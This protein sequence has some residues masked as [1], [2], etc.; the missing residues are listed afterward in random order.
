MVVL[1]P[2]EPRE[3]GHDDEVGF[4]LVGAAVVQQLLQFGAVCGVRALAFLPEPLDDFVSLTPA[5]LLA[6][7]ELRPQA[8]ILGLLLRAHANVDDGADH[9]SQLSAVLRVRQGDRYSAHGSYSCG[10]R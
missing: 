5:V 6:C 10:P 8:Q 9:W 7:A 4:A 2:G 3:V 1:L